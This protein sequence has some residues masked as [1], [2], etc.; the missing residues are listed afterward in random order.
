MQ[1][2]LAQLS[3]EE[4]G[5]ASGL[6]NVDFKIPD[7]K[8]RKH[9]EGRVKG[10][11]A[12]NMRVSDERNATAL[13]AVAGSRLHQVIVDNDKTGLDLL[14]RA[15]LPRRV[16]L[17]PLNKISKP[18]AEEKKMRDRVAEAQKLVGVARATLALDLVTFDADVKDA[19]SYVFGSTIVCADKDAARMICERLKL[20]TV[21]LEGDL[22]DSGESSYPL[23]SALPMISD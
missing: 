12:K 8:L 6:A 11:V 7:P 1:A 21:T 17:I 2:K 19:M 15:K 20:R 16:T 3:K 10:T 14:T 18:A 13:E 23:E 22:F 9:F 4:D 5:F